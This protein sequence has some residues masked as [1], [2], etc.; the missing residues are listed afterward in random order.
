MQNWDKSTL[1][2]KELWMSRNYQVI[3]IHENKSR[4]KTFVTG[5]RM[6]LWMEVCKW[7]TGVVFLLSYNYMYTRICIRTEQKWD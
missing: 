1:D 6:N 5:Y 4:I 3:R 7:L 2:N